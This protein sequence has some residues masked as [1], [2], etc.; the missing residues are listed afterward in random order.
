M[1]KITMMSGIASLTRIKK[2]S[3]AVQQLET[4]TFL[5][6]SVT[7]FLPIQWKDAPSP[8]CP[9]TIQKISKKKLFS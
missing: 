3:H 7:D 2:I 9:K 4:I 1:A 8:K 5:G 6:G